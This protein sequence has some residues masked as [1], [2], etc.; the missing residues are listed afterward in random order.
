LLGVLDLESEIKSREQFLLS[1]APTL[2][3]G[4]DLD[5]VIIDL[6]YLNHPERQ[7]HLSNPKRIKIVIEIEI[8]FWQRGPIF[9]DSLIVNRPLT[10]RVLHEFLDLQSEGRGAHYIV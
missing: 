4:S 6:G 10:P 3:L 8:G 7:S 5:C 2:Y 1:I 9:K